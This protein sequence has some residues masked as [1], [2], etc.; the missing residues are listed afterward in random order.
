MEPKGLAKAML[1]YTGGLGAAHRWRNRN[2]LTV[3]MFHRV[4]DPDHSSW[5]GSNP[6]FTLSTSF[7]AE[8]LGLLRRHY[9]PIPLTTLRQARRGEAVLP[10]CPL[11]I[12]F[13]DGWADNYEFAA[14][15][16]RAAE[17][18]AVF[19][20]ATGAVERKR[21]FWQETIYAWARHSGANEECWQAAIQ[22]NIESSLPRTSTDVG[23]AIGELESQSESV[24]QK[25]CEKLEFKDE[26]ERP[27]MM[28]IEDIQDMNQDPLFDF[29][30]H[31]VSHT[32]FTCMSDPVSE[33]KAS[34]QTLRSWL[35][36]GPLDDLAMS[37]PHGRYDTGIL[38]EAYRQ[39]F[40]L[41]FDSQ[42]TL[43]GSST[44]RAAQAIGRFEIRP[45]EKNTGDERVTVRSRDFDA[46]RIAAEIFFRPHSIIAPSRHM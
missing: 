11:L 44:L 3:L 38:E 45:Q 41:V 4:I 23:N 6:M 28:K 43:R 29:G 30:A 34:G 24:G 1:Y 26:R 32:P 14:P 25:V 20:L 33:L 27:Q 36:L 19:F 15:L 17:M 13:D 16:L 7:F 18:P 22:G 35:G 31:G 5:S 46:S 40:D 10:S 8:I 39:N 37:F 21:A 42:Q 12:T 9:S 2:H